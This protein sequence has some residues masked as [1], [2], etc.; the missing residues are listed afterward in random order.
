MSDLE[1]CQK[2]DDVLLIHEV[3][4]EKPVVHPHEKTTGIFQYYTIGS[5]FFYFAA[6]RSALWYES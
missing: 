4:R 6:V 1:A 2:A 3:P 5:G